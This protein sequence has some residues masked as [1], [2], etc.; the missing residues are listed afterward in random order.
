MISIR[1]PTALRIFSKGSI[2]FF[3]CAAL[4]YRPW[5]SAACGSNGQIFIALM[6]LASRSS[7]SAS[8]RFMKPSRSS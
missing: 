4:M 6:P 5:F 1:S 3:I 7:A 2:A 8:A